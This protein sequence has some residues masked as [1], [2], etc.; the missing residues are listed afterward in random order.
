MN[1]LLNHPVLQ[2]MP[3][4]LLRDPNFDGIKAFCSA[5]STKM[6]RFKVFAFA[7]SL[8]FILMIIFGF[9]T[10]I[11]EYFGACLML[12]ASI[13]AHVEQKR[14]MISDGEINEILQKQR[15]NAG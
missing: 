14:S 15:A 4:Q 7:V 3:Y 11:E 5:R 2:H 10:S 6:K 13:W 9:A 8:C 1:P 12:L